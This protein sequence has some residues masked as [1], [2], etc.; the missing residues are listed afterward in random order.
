MSG[1][2]LREALSTGAS[3][4]KKSSQIEIN[5]ISRGFVVL[6]MAVEINLLSF[7]NCMTRSV[8]SRVKL[9]MPHLCSPSALR[10]LAVMQI[11]PCQALCFSFNSGEA[12]MSH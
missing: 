2:M 4:V 3:S 7:I 6:I 12:V 5:P 10:M 1:C 9:H 11:K 8:C